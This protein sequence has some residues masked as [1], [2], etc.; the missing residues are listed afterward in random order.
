MTYMYLQPAHQLDLDR[1]M[2]I[3]HSAQATMATDGVHQWFNGYPD[4]T[5]LLSDIAKAQLYEIIYQQQIAGVLAIQTTPE[6]N[7]ETLKGG[8]WHSDAPYATIHRLAMHHEFAGHHLGKMAIAHALTLIRNQGI[9]HVR[10]DTHHDNKRM[11]YLMR[12]FGFG[13]RGTIHIHDPHG[14][15]ETEAYELSLN[16]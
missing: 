9:M 10:M 5:N 14:D 6:P 11:Q 1:I 4:R 15:L 8:H 3:I 2:A 16:L 7:Y 13:H 12:Q